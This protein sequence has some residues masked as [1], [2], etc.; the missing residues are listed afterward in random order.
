MIEIINLSKSFG[1]K[2]VLCGVDL[3]IHDGDAMCVIGKSG[4]G[5]SVLLKHIVGLLEPDSGSVKVDGRQI[6]KLSAKELFSLRRKIGFVFQGSALFDSYN[7]Y[8]NII[9]SMFEHGEKDTDKLKAE[10]IRVLSAVGLLPERDSTNEIEFKR[11]WLILSE[12]K[13]A[14]LSGGMKKRVGVARALVGQP[15]Y[16]F[17]DEPTTGLDP[18][19]SEQID[20]M[21]LDLTK[22]IKVTSLI[23]THDMFSVFKVANSVAMLNAGMVQYSGTPEG[24][25]NSPDPIVREFLER[26]E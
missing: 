6:D 8:E 25:R 11:E 22:K 13:P 9:L 23:I 21:I 26:Y 4:C 7:V 15:A 18:V 14:D 3:T 19:T 16:I 24:L 1:E 10:A 12:K 20:E 17:Y 2:Q 5:K